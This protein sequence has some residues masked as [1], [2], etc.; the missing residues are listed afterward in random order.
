M[1]LILRLDPC[2]VMRD[3]KE[4]IIIIIILHDKILGGTRLR[5]DMWLHYPPTNVYTNNQNHY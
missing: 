1:W 3:I 4:F 2:L 5:V